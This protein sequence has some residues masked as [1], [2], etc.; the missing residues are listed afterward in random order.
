MMLSESEIKRNIALSNFTT[1]RVGGPAEWISEPK[2]IEEVEGLIYWAKQQNIRCNIIGAGSNL[3]ISDNGLRGLSLCMRQ[4]RGAKL[5]SIS[6]SVEAL[7]GE[8]LPSLA[9]RTAKEGLHGLEWAVGIPGTVGGAVTM[10]AGAAGNSISEKIQSIDVLSIPKGKIF[11]LNCKDLDFKYRESLLQKEELVL[12]SAR[13]KLEPGYPRKELNQITNSHLNHR[14]TTQPYNQHTCGSVFRNPEPLKAGA[15]IEAIGLKG[16]RIGGAEIS[17]I[18]ANFIINK[19][20]ASSKDIQKLISI[21]Q[22]KVK[23]SYGVLLQTEVKAYGF[24]ISS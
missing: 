7:A 15:L 17:K 9:R 21:I 16:F 1:W 2:S 24:S 10:N 20:H 3:L 8:S 23:D 14:I 5:D 19:G 13:F 4:L 6:G 18:H 12:L 11:K 22:N